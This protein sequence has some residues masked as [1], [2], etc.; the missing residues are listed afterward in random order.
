MQACW[1]FRKDAEEAG[2][3][4]LHPQQRSKSEASPRRLCKV[5]VVRVLTFVLLKVTVSRP[6][7][8]AEC[9]WSVLTFVLSLSASVCS[10]P[11]ER[12]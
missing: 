9:R 3:L 8:C 6:A 2:Q 12:S 11:G 5:Q 10:W 7:G 4:L 1:Q